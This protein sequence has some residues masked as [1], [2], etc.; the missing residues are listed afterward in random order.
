MRCWH[1]CT[2]TRQHWH[3]LTRCRH[4]TPLPRLCT[5]S[6]LPPASRVKPAPK[7]PSGP[8]WVCARTAWPI[9][10]TRPTGAGDTASSPARTA[11]RVTRSSAPC[12]TTAR[13]PAWRRSRSARPARASTRRRRTGAFM[14]RPPAARTAARNSRCMTPTAG[15][16]AVT[17][18]RRRCSC[19][20]AA[21]SSPSRGWGGFISPAMRA[22]PKPC[23]AC[24]SARTAKPNRL[25]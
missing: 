19:C 16:S 11:A 2:A 13:R 23:S 3:W 7:P 12:P 8:T 5:T 14:P 4:R 20:A 6:A 17:R 21:P 18:L 25:R 9:C 15:R 22:T 10:S 24:A 1:G